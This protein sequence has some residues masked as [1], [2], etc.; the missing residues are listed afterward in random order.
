MSRADEGE[1]PDVRFLDYGRAPVKVQLREGGRIGHRSV[2][3]DSRA[4][5]RMEALVPSICREMLMKKMMKDFVEKLRRVIEQPSPS[6][7]ALVGVITFC[8]S[9]RLSS[10]LLSIP[11]DEHFWLAEGVLVLDPFRL[12]LFSGWLLLWI[13]CTQMLIVSSKAFGKFRF[14]R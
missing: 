11:A 10:D 9:A 14:S 5:G 4:S 1:T 12:A 2:F 13:V 6:L 8:F 7:A 3:T